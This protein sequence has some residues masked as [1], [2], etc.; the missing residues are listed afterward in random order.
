MLK[1]N[2]RGFVLSYGGDARN[3]H[4]PNSYGPF[5]MENTNIRTMRMG[6]RIFSLAINAQWLS[7]HS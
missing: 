3:A 5:N 6:E 4:D 2:E 7:V 1:N